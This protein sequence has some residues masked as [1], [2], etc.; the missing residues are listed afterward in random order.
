MLEKAKEKGNI[1]PVEMPPFG[2]LYYL[3]GTRVTHT[4]GTISNFRL[5]VKNQNKKQ[6]N[7]RIGLVQG[8]VC[9]WGLIWS[10]SNELLHIIYQFEMTPQRNTIYLIYLI[11]LDNN[12][13]ANGI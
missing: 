8:K 7:M 1:F 2:S 4:E 12:I 5:Q 11:A 3:Y 10:R 9:Y 6:K 13:E